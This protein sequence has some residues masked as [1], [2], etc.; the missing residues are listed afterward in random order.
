MIECKNN[1]TLL[2]IVCKMLDN[3]DN[4]LF[5]IAATGDKKNINS[6]HLLDL[7]IAGV[8]SDIQFA[9]LLELSPALLEGAKLELS[10]ELLVNIIRR[11]VI[12]FDSLHDGIIIADQDTVVRYLNKSFE[13][14]TLDKFNRV[15]GKIVQTVRPGHLS[16]V[17]SNGT[18]LFGATRRFQGTD[19]ITDIHPIRSEG[20]N[21]GGITVARDITEIKQMQ[22]QLSKYKEDYNDLLKQTKGYKA[23]YT[24]ADI[25]GEDEE[26]VKAKKTGEKIAASKISVLIRG[27]SGTGK[28]L[29]AHAIHLASDR[30]NMPFVT[31]NCAAIPDSLLESELFGYVEGAFSGA[32][33][34]GRQ[35]L[36]MLANNGTLFLDEI[37]EMNI[38]LQT[39]LL[40]VI[41][42]NQI[43]PLGGENSVNINVRIIA[44][45]NADLEKKIAQNKFRADLFYRLNVSQLFIPPLRERKKDIYKTAYYLLDK[46]F[47]KHPLAPLSFDKDTENILQAFHWPGNVRELENTI[48]FIGSITENNVISSNCLPPVFYRSDNVLATQEV[49]QGNNCSSSAP[50]RKIYLQN[51]K[52]EEEKKIIMQLLDLYG[53][54]VEGK[55]KVAAELGIAIS[56]F[57]NKLNILGIR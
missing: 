50:S 45:T 39:K 18:P 17:I 35:G 13:R 2:S 41:S 40:R 55:K 54:N 38:D 21:M 31:V 1:D 32:K 23:I 48:V 51:A 19:Y 25:I 22:V 46:H 16:K 42:S 27:E 3:A 28:E 20:K 10:Q 8:S 43:Q 5:Y 11:F 44:A 6:R 15:V 4:E 9:S 57:Y 12:I 30:A 53:S 56:T 14:I 37:G 24:F 34:G 52:N 47:S 29:F 33:K 26:L 7:F 49:N 36:M